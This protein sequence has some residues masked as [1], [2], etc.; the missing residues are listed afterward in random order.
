MR[1]ISGCM[2]Y[3][4]NP[5]RKNINNSNQFKNFRLIMSAST[6]NT[7][8]ESFVIDPF[9]ADINPGTTRGQKIVH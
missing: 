9:A 3:W 1:L 2:S 8:P 6:A 5:D 7:E 4:S